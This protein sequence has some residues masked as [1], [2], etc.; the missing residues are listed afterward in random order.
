[1]SARYWYFSAGDQRFCFDKH[2]RFRCPL[3]AA[4]TH[5]S[6]AVSEDCTEPAIIS[7]VAA[8]AAMLAADGLLLANL[9]VRAHISHNA[10]RLRVDGRLTDRC[11]I[12][13]SRMERLG[14]PCWI[15]EKPKRR[16]AQSRIASRLGHDDFRRVPGALWYRSSKREAREWAHGRAN[17]AKHPNR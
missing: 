2:P 7:T 11:A 17:A 14:F 13:G 12:C 9:L 16:D 6:S 10:G 8:A 3:A 5:Q 1:M 15:E 4:V